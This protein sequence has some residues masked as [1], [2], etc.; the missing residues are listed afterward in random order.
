MKHAEPGTLQEHLEACK[1]QSACTHQTVC[2]RNTTSHI[3]R[4]G[5]EGQ[6]RHDRSEPRKDN[7]AP[8]ASTRTTR[9]TARSVRRS[10]LGP[11]SC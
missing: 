2:N 5:E 9:T 3:H 6:A 8:G 10:A 7:R 11:D 1:K 4:L